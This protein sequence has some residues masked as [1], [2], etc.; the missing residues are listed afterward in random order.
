M[1]KRQIATHITQQVADTMSQGPPTY[2][3]EGTVSLINDLSILF[4]LTIQID[5]KK[6]KKKISGNS[7]LVQWLGLNA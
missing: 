1:T 2:V 6:K 3:T 4:L 7:L 5:Q